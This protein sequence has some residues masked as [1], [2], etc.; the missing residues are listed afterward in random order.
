MSSNF[1]FGQK[2]KMHNILCT[3]EGIQDEKKKEN[4]SPDTRVQSNFAYTNYLIQEQRNI[5]W[6][7]YLRLVTKR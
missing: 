5:V 7:R 3:A 2:R 1:M 6:T 4:S